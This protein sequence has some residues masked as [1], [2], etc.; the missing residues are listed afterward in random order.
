MNITTT[1]EL[2]E[3][4][5]RAFAKR[6]DPAITPEAF[7]AILVKEQARRWADADE[8]ELLALMQPVG[9]EIAAAAGGDPAKIAAALEA[10]K[11]AALAALQS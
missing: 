9:A 3:K 6:V 5:A 10:G 4:E 7:A 2:D 8:S 11:T 1:I